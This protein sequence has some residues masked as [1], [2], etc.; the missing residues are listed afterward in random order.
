MKVSCSILAGGLA[1]AVLSLSA[2]SAGKHDATADTPV[3]TTTTENALP[4][5]G[6]PQVAIGDKNFTEQFLLGELYAQALSARGYSV[7]LN[8]NIGPTEV[9]MQAIYSGRL[10]MYPE[11]LST[12][13]ADVAGYKR[14]FSTAD[15][16]YGAARRYARLHGLRLLAPTPFS[17][18]GGIAVTRSYGSTQGLRTIADL[19]KVAP[20]LTLGAP[21]QFQQTPGGLG[22]LEQ[23][24][25][26]VPA[27]F[28]PL[29]IGAQYQALDQ[30]RV[31][32]AEVS[33]TD[34]QLA[35]GDYRLLRDPDKVFGWGQAV[36]V[37]PLK[38]LVAEGPAFAATI[39]RVSRLLSTP[40]MQELNAEVDVYQRDPAVVAK[41]FLQANGLVPLTAS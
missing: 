31:Q 28:T 4:G 33:T 37:V 7:Q 32:A 36:P 15:A 19:R 24:Y 35:N 41:E 14:S 12:W 8:R 39:D 26:F 6:K 30:G 9:T 17:D 18:T 23:V 10:D 16:A 13:N 25:G 11:Y 38:V 3:A 21:P 1:L 20:T 29:A 40:A 22:A 27:T 5:T 34:G 2:C